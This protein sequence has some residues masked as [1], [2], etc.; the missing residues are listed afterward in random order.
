MPSPFPGMDPYLEDPA[1]WEGFHLVL[2]TEC[3]YQLA[4]RLPDGYV[5]NVGERVQLI[6]TLDEA[7]AQYLP[8]V[9]VTKEPFRGDAARRTGDD[10]GGGPAVAVAPVVIPSID[11]IEVREA[12]V[13]IQR[14]PDYELVTSV[15][16]LSPSNK[17]GEGIGEY[18]AKRRALVGQGVHV[19]EI[20]LLL[21]GTR[22][23]LARPLPPGDYFALIFYGDRRPDVGVYAWGL[24]DPLPEIRVPLRRPDPDVRLD[25]AAVVTSAYDRGKY[26]R[27][28]RYSAGPPA[29]VP[30]AA[31]E[32]V[33]STA[34]NSLE[35]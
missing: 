16:L 3:M 6:S 33:T 26:R 8:D 19:A 2:M 11:A 24:R 15:E 7:A 31:A 20:D 29:T 32:W 14:L 34:R 13:K 10:W 28:L 1:F 30:R 12:Y 25:L 17:F 35:G 21:R 9:V 5:A 27:K 4:E 18:R 23:E 22:T